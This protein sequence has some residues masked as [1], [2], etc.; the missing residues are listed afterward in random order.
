VEAK[1]PARITLVGRAI[2]TLHFEADLTLQIALHATAMPF[3]SVRDDEGWWF[4]AS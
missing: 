2:S 1:K 3:A 4:W